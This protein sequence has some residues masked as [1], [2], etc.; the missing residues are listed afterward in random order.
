MPRTIE[1]TVYTID[2]LSDAARE[3]A[4]AWYRETCLDHEWYDFVYEDFGT[5][6]GILGVTLRTTPVRFPGGRTRDKPQVFFQGYADN[7]TMPRS[8]P[9]A[10]ILPTAVPVL[11]AYS[12]ARLRVR[13]S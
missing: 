3:R 12:Q 9:K 10:L 8:V 5:I 4:R 11:S 6:C 13:Y 2:E 1:T 7:R